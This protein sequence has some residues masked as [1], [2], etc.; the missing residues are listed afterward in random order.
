MSEMAS[1]SEPELA[2]PCEADARAFDPVAMHFIEV[3]ARRATGQPDSVKRLL[4]IKVQQA[5]A[6]LQTRLSNS[7]QK[8]EQTIEKTRGQEGIFSAIL[9]HLAQLRHQALGDATAQSS[10]DYFRDNWSRLS[11]ARKVN[12]ALDQA[13]R[14]A[15]PINSHG[16]VLRS[17]A[18]M[19]D[20]SPAY[21]NHFVSY[22]DALL[23]LE[24]SVSTQAPQARP[25]AKPAKANLPAVGTK[26][27][28]P[29][30]GLAKRPAQ[31]RKP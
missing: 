11:T 3:L 5:L 17:L 22:V 30:R 20:A 8:T 23:A 7:P 10:V 9:A 15:G 13:P 18:Q 29:G 16:L 25:V 6:E 21:L 26:S 19:R 14:N 12:Q 31:T 4:D 28:R 27:N 2:I 24:S 1:E